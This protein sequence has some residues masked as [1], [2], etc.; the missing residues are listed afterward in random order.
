[1]PPT[2]LPS[3]QNFS[4]CFDIFLIAPDISGIAR[5]KSHRV[6]GVKVDPLLRDPVEGVGQ[7]AGP[8]LTGE[9]EAAPLTDAPSR[10]PRRFLEDMR[11]ARNGDDLGISP[12]GPETPDARQIALIFRHLLRKSGQLPW[13]VFRRNHKVGTPFDIHAQTPSIG[14]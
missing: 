14:G 3:F 10:L 4:E 7:R 8:V 9:M 2:P 13:T 1:M 6:D 12:A 11:V 5:S